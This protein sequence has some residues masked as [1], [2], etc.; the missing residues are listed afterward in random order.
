M[1]NLREQLPG[2]TVGDPRHEG[3]PVVMELDTVRTED[4]GY[5]QKATSTNDI[6]SVEEEVVW[7]LKEDALVVLSGKIEAAAASID[8]ADAVDIEIKKPSRIAGKKCIPRFLFGGGSEEQ[9]V[10]ARSV[11]KALGCTSVWPVESKYDESC[12]HLIL[13]DLKRTEKYLCACAAGKV[14]IIDLDLLY[15]NLL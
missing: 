1:F 5:R 3:A 11:V 2:S 4:T 7:E 10:S 9:V 13:W 6:I 15:R 12:T 8:T 14:S